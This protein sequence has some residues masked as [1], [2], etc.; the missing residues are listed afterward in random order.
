MPLELIDVTTANGELVGQRWIFL[1]ERVHRQLRP[2]LDRDY[3]NQMLRIFADGAR[4]FV[5]VDGE[6]VVGVAVYRIYENTFEGRQIYVDDLVSDE[7]RRSAGIGKAMMARLVQIAKES[8][9]VAFNLD[10]GV[11]RAQAH[12]FYFREGMVVSAF[13]FGMRI[14]E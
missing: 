11:Q 7:K 5:A 6:S 2:Q 3:V 4:M 14:S 8:G 10:S 13:H 1:S 12:K 9:C